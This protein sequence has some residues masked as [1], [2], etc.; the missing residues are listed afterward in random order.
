MAIGGRSLGVDVDIN[1]RFVAEH[2]VDV[3][4]AVACAEC[5]MDRREGPLTRLHTDE[6]EEKLKRA[7]D[8]RG[9]RP[10]LLSVQDIQGQILGESWLGGGAV[11]VRLSRVDTFDSSS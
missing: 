2:R 7:S 5:V 1:S 8:P 6:R 9:L 11:E 3:V 4:G 10:V